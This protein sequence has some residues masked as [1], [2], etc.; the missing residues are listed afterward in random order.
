ML[1]LV[2]L[3]TAVHRLWYSGNAEP[4]R[5]KSR[6]VPLEALLVDVN[7]PVVRA[8][9]PRLAG[10]ASTHHCARRAILCGRSSSSRPLVSTI[11]TVPSV[12]LTMKSGV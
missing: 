11:H 10:V 7:E 8:A 2:Y 5:Q 3:I 1:A 6:P 4:S 9:F 12:V